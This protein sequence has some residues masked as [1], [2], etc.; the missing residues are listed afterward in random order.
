[1]KH[2]PEVAGFVLGWVLVVLI[3]AALLYAV[4]DGLR[5]LVS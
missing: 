4:I 3:G 5:S 1:M 2:L